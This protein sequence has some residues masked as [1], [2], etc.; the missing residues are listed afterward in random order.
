MSEIFDKLSADFA[1]A[2]DEST[3]L[4]SECFD[5]KHVASV[6]YPTAT[7]DAMGRAHAPCDGYRC[8]VWIPI[9]YSDREFYEEEREYCAGE[10]L[11]LNF[12]FLEIGGKRPF[13]KQFQANQR[14][15]KWAAENAELIEQ[16]EALLSWSGFAM[17]VLARA[18]K[19]CGFTPKQSQ[20]INSMLEKAKARAE[21]PVE[22]PEADLGHFGDVGSRYTVNV[23]VERC[24]W[25]E[26]LYGDFAIAT[27]KTECR[28]TLVYKG[29]TP[30][31]SWPQRSGGSISGEGVQGALSFTV[32]AHDDYKGKSQTL[33]NRPRSEGFGDVA[34]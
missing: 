32:K 5:R 11:P 26:G 10:Y 4:L 9:S 25:F 27:L 14:R 1:R 33:I 3:G 7:I 18:K 19:D 16:I 29:S 34:E 31:I 8:R 6:I 22:A 28:K 17:D 15:A 20:A 2:Y 13:S 21:K 24:M 12:D 30:P 23:T